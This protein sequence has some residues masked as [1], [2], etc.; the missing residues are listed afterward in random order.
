MSFIESA[1]SQWPER[2]TQALRDA[3]LWD[4]ATLQL[5]FY[6]TPRRL[7]VKIHG[8]PVTQCAE[9][10]LVKGPSVQAAF[11][12]DGTPSNAALGFC[13]KWSITPEQLTRTEENG[14][15]YVAFEQDLPQAPL[16]EVL[17]EVLT[18]SVTELQGPLFMRWLPAQPGVAELRFPRP[19]RWL[20]CLLDGAPLPFEFAGLQAGNTT[21]AHRTLAPSKQVIVPH[22]DTYEAV[23]ETQAFVIPCPDKRRQRIQEEIAR[24]ASQEQGVVAP[25]DVE[26]LL[27]TLTH[28]VEWPQAVVGRFESAYLDLPAVVLAIVLK[29]HQKCLPLRQQADTVGDTTPLLPCFLTIANGVAN[30]AAR[31]IIEEGNARVVRARF[32]D[33]LFFYQEDLATPLQDRFLSLRGIT[34][35]KGLGSVAD[36][37]SRLEQ[38]ARTVLAAGGADGWD[39]TA[40][41]HA[42]RC[43][44]AD[45]TTHMVFEF[46]E[47]EGQVGRD[48]ALKQGLAPQVA[49]AIAE[50][51]LP[52]FPGDTL[53]Q[54]DLGHFLGVLD[55]V[56]TLTAIFSQK[57]FKAPSGSRDPLGLRRL[58]AG[59]LQLYRVRNGEHHQAGP[60]STALNHQ[61]LLA[62][63]HAAYQ[64]LAAQQ[65]QTAQLRPWHTVQA[66]IEAFY[67]ARLKTF[68]AELDM[69]RDLVE[70]VLDSD[71][72]WLQALPTSAKLIEAV[73]ELASLRLK[74]AAQF[75]VLKTAGERAGNILEKAPAAHQGEVASLKEQDP[76]QVLRSLSSA[77]AGGLEQAV[78]HQLLAC[79]GLLEAG[80]SSPSQL[81]ALAAAVNALLD[82][83]MIFD[84]DAGA[85]QARLAL[86][87]VAHALFMQVAR[88]SLVSL[89]GTDV[90]PAADNDDVSLTAPALG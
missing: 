43:L 74:Q 73:D 66:D 10:L 27:D 17:P 45:L 84:P 2:L 63:V 13:R 70:A 23:L 38:L 64:T 65:G 82:G 12:A 62:V 53:P 69:P 67:R 40:L 55:R 29:S 36:K 35:Q 30:D 50:H 72:P 44:K 78:Y 37:M 85:R 16:A 1:L 77:M 4:S 61:P 47:L 89:E 46:T 60:L 76:E 87:R 25:R 88:F 18:R 15:L 83:A 6:A 24:A 28:L 34:F 19:I 21:W 11:Q 81:L 51:Y 32:Q 75:S 22:V 57:S 90:P 26:E 20:V 8:L 39:T 41:T 59:L 48:Y 68:V 5:Q 7:A 42:V 86:L 33:A 52:R 56:D 49:E 58:V 79:D 31:H 3:R 14:Q 9:R 54:T 71:N 80:V